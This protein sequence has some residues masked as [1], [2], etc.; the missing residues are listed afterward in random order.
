MIADV[1][2]IF[3]VFR[4]MHLVMQIVGVNVLIRMARACILSSD[5]CRTGKK[6]MV[7]VQ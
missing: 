7:D 6:N 5:I 2:S 1:P 3:Y 4:A